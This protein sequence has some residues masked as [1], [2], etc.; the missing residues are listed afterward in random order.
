RYL[1]LEKLLRR[2][3][4]L[5][6]AR[7]QCEG[8][9]EMGRLVRNVEGSYLFVQG[10]PGAGKTWTGARLITDLINR[11]KRVAIA[12]Q[13]HKAIHK[14]LSE[15]EA[16]ARAEGVS[17]RGLKKATGGNADSYYDEGSRLIS[18]ATEASDFFDADE[19]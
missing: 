8:L 19:E 12:S 14:L 18:N 4:P 1:H 16:D 9:G 2:E 17:F 6:G 15:I 13:S 10:P 3:Q 7:V 11:G 5:A